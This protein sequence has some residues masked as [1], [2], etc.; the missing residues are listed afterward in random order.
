MLKDCNEMTRDVLARRDVYQKKRSRRLQIAAGT[1]AAAVLCCAA[2]FALAPGKQG[3]KEQ[4]IDSGTTASAPA[5]EQTAQSYDISLFVN[6]I[7]RNTAGALRADVDIQVLPLPETENIPQLQ[8]LKELALPETLTETDI[9]AVYVRSDRDIAQY[10]RLHEYV[11]RFSDRNSEKELRVAFSS[12]GKPIRD[13]LFT[14]EGAK[15]SRI[16]GVEMIVFRY[17]NILYTEFTAGGM[18]FDL[19]AQGL[20]EEEFALC[21]AEI[22][23][24]F[25]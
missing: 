19:E 12:Q 1:A 7:D 13:Y 4:V 24:Q 23:Q 18:F 3:P 10:N 11:C 9:Y 20:S 25:C 17:E 6:E 8:F 16:N 15:A 21:T 5:P 2:V 22:L 14:D